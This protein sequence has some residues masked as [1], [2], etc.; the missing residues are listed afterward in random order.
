MEETLADLDR[1][2][3]TGHLPA[4]RGKMDYAHFMRLLITYKYT[5]PVL[6]HGLTE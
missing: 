6:L 4:G 1:D 2:G 3:A 5:G